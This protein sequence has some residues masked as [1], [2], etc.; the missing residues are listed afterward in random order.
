MPDI[1]QQLSRVTILPVLMVNSE[2]EATGISRAQPTLPA[3][4]YYPFAT[5]PAT[6][7]RTGPGFSAPNG[8]YFCQNHLAGN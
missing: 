2:E 3:T 5:L 1:R 4:G 6:D 7:L 8:Y